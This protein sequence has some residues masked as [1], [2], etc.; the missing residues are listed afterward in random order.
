MDTIK[1]VI[2]SRPID[3]TSSLFSK[4]AQIYKD[5]GIGFLYRAWPV[6]MARGLPSAAITLTSY[7]LAFEYLNGSVKNS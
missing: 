6:A 3:K 4:V 1:T 2:E 7:D 5:H